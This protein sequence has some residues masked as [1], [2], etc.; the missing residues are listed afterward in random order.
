[1]LGASRHGGGSQAATEAVLFTAK[2]RKALSAQTSISHRSE[3][4]SEPR[5]IPASTVGHSLEL[6]RQMLNPPYR[7]LP[8]LTHEQNS[9]LSLSFGGRL[10]HI[11]R[12][13]K[14]YNCQY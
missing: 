5:L 8:G 10:L 11:N 14:Q 6:P 7:G 1:M 9:V 12:S 3:R 4:V 2:P 13:L